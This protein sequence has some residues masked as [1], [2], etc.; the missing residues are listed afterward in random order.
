MNKQLK[1][2]LTVIAGVVALCGT[3]YVALYFIAKQTIG[4]MMPITDPARAS[5]IGHEIVNYTLPPGYCEQSA[6]SALGYKVIII[7]PQ[8]GITNA[9]TIVLMEGP[10]GWNGDEEE[11]LQGTGL[12]EN[13]DDLNMRIVSTQ[14]VTI[15]GRPVT[16][17]TCESTESDKPVQRW[18]S[19]IFPGKGN[20]EV[21]ISAASVKDAWDQAAWD[22]FLASIK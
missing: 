11:A 12:Q 15:Q 19:G 1:I 9:M 13:V 7:G 20:T 5:K 17:A 16:L 18:V 10:A 6:S 3:S 2:A 8:S 22:S 4:Q 21:T 14:T